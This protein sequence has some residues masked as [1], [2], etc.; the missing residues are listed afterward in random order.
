M[1]NIGTL[2]R[3]GDTFFSEIGSDQGCQM[4]SF[5]TKNPNFGKLWRTLDWKMLKY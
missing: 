1:V 4:V 3:G 5:Q 2:L